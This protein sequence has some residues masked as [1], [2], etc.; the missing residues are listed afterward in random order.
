LNGHIIHVLLHLVSVSTVPPKNPTTLELVF[1]DDGSGVCSI[2]LRQNYQ[3]G[4][5][6]DVDVSKLQ[7]LLDEHVGGIKGQWLWIWPV[8]AKSVALPHAEITVDIQIVCAQIDA[9]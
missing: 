9:D 6:V 8:E 1:V 5:A 2:D 3:I 4:V 7:V